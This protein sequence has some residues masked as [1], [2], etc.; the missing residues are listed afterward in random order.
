MKVKLCQVFSL[1][2]CLIN[3]SVCLSISQ[4]VPQYQEQARM[5]M[6]PGAT[7][8]HLISSKV[9]RRTCVANK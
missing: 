2:A 6:L 5:E 9:P 7:S 1:F 3:V 8:G 4:P